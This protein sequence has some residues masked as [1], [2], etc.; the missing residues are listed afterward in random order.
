MYGYMILIRFNQ[1]PDHI[2]GTKVMALEKAKKQLSS[3]CV[4]TS[5]RGS[6]MIMS[7]IR[8]TKSELFPWNWQNLSCFIMLKGIET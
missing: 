7:Q 3:F 6:S 4:F 1:G 2:R 5:L 8:S